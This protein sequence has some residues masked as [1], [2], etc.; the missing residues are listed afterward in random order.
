MH[1]SQTKERPG[2]IGARTY[3]TYCGLF[4]PVVGDGFSW[5]PG[6]AC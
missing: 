3:L 5:V 6:G 1:S 2:I 4:V